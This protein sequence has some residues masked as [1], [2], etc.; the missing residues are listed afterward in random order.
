MD[1][2]KRLIGEVHRRSVWQVLTLYL[3]MSWGALQ[4]VETL[5][6]SAGLP[7]QLPALALILLVIGLPVVIA[8]AFVQE[9]TGISRDPDVERAGDTGTHPA[10]KPGEGEAA[11]HQPETGL[12]R[13]VGE[14]PE[15]HPGSRVRTVLTWRNALLGGV[16]AF[17]LW[18]VVATFLLSTGRP[19]GPAALDAAERP[20]V[21]VLPLQAL[22]IGG[23]RDDGFSQGFHD[24]IITRLSK[25]SGLRVTSRTS[26]MQYAGQAGNMRDIAR[27]LGVDMLLEGSVQRTDGQIALNIQL[28]DGTTDEHVW[29]ESYNREYSLANVF[30]IQRELAEEIASQLRMSLS[31]EEATRLA[32]APTSN[33]DAYQS[34]LQAN[35]FYAAGPRM[36]EFQTAID[37]YERAVEQ[38]PGFA[39]AHAR[40]AFSLGQRWQTFPDDRTSAV[41][42]RA[43]AAL[44]RAF[45]L[46]PGLPDA[47][48]AE[49]QLHYAMEG[50]WGLALAS[51]SKAGVTGLK[52][53]YLHLLGAAQRRLGDFDGAI[54]SWEE[55]V[56]VDPLSSH[57]VE[58]LGT[59]Y[60]AVGRL[61]EAEEQL[62]RAIQLDPTAT[63]PYNF[64]FE[65][66]TARDGS[67]HRARQLLADAREA[68]GAPWTGWE[69][70]FHYLDRDWERALEGAQGAGFRADLLARLGRTAEAGVLAAEAEREWQREATNAGDD[71][72]F[73]IRGAHIAAYRA[74]AEIAAA[75][76]DSALRM[77]PVSSDAVSGPEI[78]FGAAGVFARI[79][80]NDR[81]VQL[82][83]ELLAVP[84]Q[85]TGKSIG[86]EPAF[87]GLRDAA[88]FR[89]LVDG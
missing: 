67:T 8:T 39:L 84:S 88:R 85:H 46:D 20:S 32:D 3:A 42:A 19:I 66:L 2:L 29:A 9:G 23:E 69:A 76:A 25:I 43:R 17:A 40:L 80:R 38:D 27:A 1:Q 37:L 33:P 55:M 70:Y 35:Q 12:D 21:A 44:A 65:V 63:A 14:R 68:T 30:S 15:V 47:Y 10:P 54:A 36:T 64:L 73:Q 5:V 60:Q 56:R 31:P 57:Y 50:N 83:E 52:S 61:D 75:R 13:A 62:R 41:E 87:D 82:L 45:E 49:G 6:D 4:V 24:E 11:L 81:A 74:D 72:F 59:V 89:A 53:D 79:G 7:E 77:L 22:S 48:L 28:I 86:M 16:G 26:V 34:Y 58:D 51:L 18:G 78:L 71:A